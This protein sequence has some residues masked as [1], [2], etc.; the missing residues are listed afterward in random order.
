M[1]QAWETDSLD[2]AEAE[3]G[4]EALDTVAEAEVCTSWV[5]RARAP[6]TTGAAGARA[7]TATVAAVAGQGGRRKTPQQLPKGARVASKR[8]LPR[9]GEVAFAFH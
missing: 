3:E 2:V 9:W 8:Q 6:G 7:A 5:E 1:Y 4:A